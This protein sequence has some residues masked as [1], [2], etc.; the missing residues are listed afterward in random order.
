MVL[1]RRAV[2]WEKGSYWFQEDVVGFELQVERRKCD[3]DGGK[4]DAATKDRVKRT[5]WRR[6]ENVFS[7]VGAIN[8]VKRVVKRDKWIPCRPGRERR[9]A[10]SSKLQS[11]SAASLLSIMSATSGIAVS[12]ELAST[13]ADAVSSKNVRFLKIS[14]QNG[15]NYGQSFY[16]LGSI[17][18]LTW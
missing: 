1:L 10:C 5:T 2:H 9:E 3:G 18:H 17:S 8:S 13:F 11:S 12:P 7:A 16:K 4:L 6:S 15:L 14:I